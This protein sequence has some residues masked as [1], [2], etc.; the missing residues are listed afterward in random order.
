M[1]QPLR[2]FLRQAVGN[3]SPDG[4][5]FLTWMPRSNKL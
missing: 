4:L 5:P 2:S 1:V 3:G